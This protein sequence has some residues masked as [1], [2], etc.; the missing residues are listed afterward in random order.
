MGLGIG[1]GTRF[2]CGKKVLR[3]WSAFRGPEQQPSKIARCRQTPE[4]SD[5]TK[6]QALETAFHRILGLVKNWRFITVLCDWDEHQLAVT[7]DKVTAMLGSTMLTT[8]TLYLLV[9]D[10][11][12][13]LDRQQSYRPLRKEI[14]L[15]YKID[16]LDGQQYA[17]ILSYIRRELE[18]LIKDHTMVKLKDGSSRQIT[19]V[20][21]FRW[22][23]PRQ[24][25]RGEWRPG[26][27]CKVVDDIFA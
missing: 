17:G 2:G 9:P 7:Y 8:K 19:N 23:S 27:I 18:T 5:L 3:D 20:S 16:T 21:D 1:A 13:A 14:R 26:T 24:G 12:V 25:L 11:F 15:P 4:F 6:P 22:L 10:L